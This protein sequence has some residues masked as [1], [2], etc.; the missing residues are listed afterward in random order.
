MKKNVAVIVLGILFALSLGAV[1][2]L[3][4]ILG[5]AFAFAGVELF[6][7]LWLVFA[8]L[9]VITLICSCFAKKNII[10]SRV[11]LTISV[12]FSLAIHIY[13]LILFATQGSID[14]STI[15][16]FAVLF[17]SALVGLIAMLISYKAKKQPKVIE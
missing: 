16:L 17:V 13:S 2:Y 6:V 12:V 10:V 4:V 3:Y 1:S 5:I 8:V 14:A 7:N 15:L 9:A 11:A